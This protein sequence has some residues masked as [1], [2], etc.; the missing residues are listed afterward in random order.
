MKKTLFQSQCSLFR[1]YYWKAKE[2]WCMG[3]IPEIVNFDILTNPPAEQIELIKNIRSLPYKS[4]E[5]SELKRRLLAISASSIQIG[6]RGERYHSLHSGFICFDIDGTG[7]DTDVV[8]E[9]VK[10]I[11]Y[12][13]FCSRSVSGKGIWGLIPISNKDMHSEHFDA[14]EVSFMGIGIKID[15]APRNVASLRFLSYDPDAYVNEQAIVFTKI[16]E[17]PKPTD[18]ELK[19]REQYKSDQD[20]W[21]NFR[22]NVEFDDINDILLNA[23]WSYHSTSGAKVRYTRPGKSTRAGISADYHTDK[24][25]FYIFSSNAPGLEYF[26]DLGSERFAGSAATILLAYAANGDKKEAYKLMK[27]M[28]F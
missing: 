3:K 22:N 1:P 26:K 20:I 13:C 11:P 14:L 4:D 2:R 12:V 7:Q 6:G 8:F 5:Q 17:K 9:I 21:Q 25:T 27:Q 10:R 24:R 28:G 18:R 15:P 23:G 19:F 16:K